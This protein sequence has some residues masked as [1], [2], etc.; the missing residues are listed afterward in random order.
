MAYVLGWVSDR[1]FPPGIAQS[2]KLSSQ[3][4]WCGDDDGRRVLCGLV[5]ITFITLSPW[6]K[7]LPK[8]WVSA[9]W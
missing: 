9:M 1:C 4:R 2:V 8:G 5:T 7:R 3:F 6:G